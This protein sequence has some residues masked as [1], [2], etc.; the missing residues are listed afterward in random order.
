MSKYDALRDYLAGRSAEITVRVEDLDAVI[1]G[2]LPP[3]A[4][5]DARWWIPATRIAGR[6]ETQGSLPTPILRGAALSS[7][8]RPKARRAGSG[9]NVPDV[10]ACMR[11]NQA[12]AAAQECQTSSLA[13]GNASIHP[14]P[15]RRSAPGR[16]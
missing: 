6:G 1:P 15:A 9:H 10:F 11:P 12:S 2:G 14:P 5:K 4:S 16:P 8:P 13:C 3:S 7:G